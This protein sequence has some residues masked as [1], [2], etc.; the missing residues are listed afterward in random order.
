MKTFLLAASAS[1]LAASA[2][3]GA[4][5]ICAPVD[6][7]KVVVEPTTEVPTLLFR[8]TSSYVFESD[9]IKGSDASGDALTNELELGYRIPLAL[10]WLDHPDAGWY[11]RLGARYTRSDFG[12]DG[13]LPIPNHLQ[14]ASGVVA[15][16]YLVHGRIGFLLQTRPGFYFENEITS[17]AFDSPTTIALIIPFSESFSG[18]IGASY[19]ALRSYPAIPA[20]GFNWK[21][22]SQWTVLAVPP[23]PRITF[24][25]T[26]NLAFWAGG[27]L[28]MAGYKVDSHDHRGGAL[29]GTVLT[30]TEHRAGAGLTWSSKNCAVEIGGGYAFGRKFDYHRAE[31]GYETDEGAPYVRVEMRSAF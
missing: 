23:E 9:F 17:G 31:Q 28:V 27:E 25:A 4:P 19:S 18:I 12:N 24:Q 15:L 13:G 11:L 2:F 22:N 3:A 29:D 10:D 21:I 30:Y 6:H 5:V 14:G 16:E 26:E 1:L 7:K 8:S 20:I